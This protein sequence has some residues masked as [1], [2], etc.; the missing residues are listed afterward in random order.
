MVYQPRRADAAPNQLMDIVASGKI[1]A[2]KSI[3]R[4]YGAYVRRAD[5]QAFKKFGGGMLNNYGAHQIDAALYMTGEKV[6][7]VFCDKNIVASAGDADDV[8]KIF[9]RME[10]GVTVDIDINQAAGVSAPEWVING[11]CG[12]VISQVGPD[13]QKQFRLRYFDPKGIPAITASDALA[14]ANRSYNNDVPLPWVEEVIPLD[15]SYAIDFYGKVYEYFGEDKPA[16]VPVEQTLYV[17]E[18]IDRC[19]KDAEL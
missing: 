10:S 8:V 13:G 11:S 14:A 19:H 5:W 2:L 12:G 9:F 15:G 6:K 4:S 1:G 17:M 18:L 16:Y 7:R 3:R